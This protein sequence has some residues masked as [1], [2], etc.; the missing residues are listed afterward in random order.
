MA[1]SQNMNLSKTLIQIKLL[2][3]ETHAH[4]TRNTSKSLKSEEM[5]ESKMLV[6]HLMKKEKK[7]F[8]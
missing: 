3:K 8:F 5:G 4:A 1:A 2:A 7:I 6:S